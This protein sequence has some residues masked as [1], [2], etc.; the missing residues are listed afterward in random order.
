MR[1]AKQFRRRLTLTKHKSKL[2]CCFLEKP[3]TDPQPS[4][5][6]RGGL[7]FYDPLEKKELPLGIETLA[8]V[9]SILDSNWNFSGWFDGRESACLELAA[10]FHLA[11]RKQNSTFFRKLPSSVARRTKSYCLPQ[12]CPDFHA[13]E[14]CTAMCKGSGQ[15]SLCCKMILQLH[16][17]ISLLR[18]QPA[19]TYDPRSA[20][21]LLLDRICTT[22]WQDDTM[23]APRWLVSCQFFAPEVTMMAMKKQSWPDNFSFQLFVSAFANITQWWYVGCLL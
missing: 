10:I 18:E 8:V 4:W 15:S 20:P 19:V 5:L 12:L 11:T 1:A 9:L 13:L 23:P 14:N 6:A 16:H 21:L 2:F 3:Q 7:S 22:R 17:P